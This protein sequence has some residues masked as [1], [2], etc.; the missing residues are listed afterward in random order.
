MREYE[1]NNNKSKH[2]TFKKSKLR[3]VAENSANTEG[4]KMQRPRKRKSYDKY[5]NT[6][7]CYQKSRFDNRIGRAHTSIMLSGMLLGCPDV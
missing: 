7:N 6:D 1:H 5:V 3:V 2:G 4:G